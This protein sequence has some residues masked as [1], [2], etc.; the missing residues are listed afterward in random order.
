MGPISSVPIWTFHPPDDEWDGQAISDADEFGNGTITD[1]Y[2]F[3]QWAYDDWSTDYCYCY[4]TGVTNLSLIHRI[5][6]S[7]SVT[8]LPNDPDT[9]T[10]PSDIFTLASNTFGAFY[11][12]EPALMV[13]GDGKLQLAYG[14]TTSI[15]TISTNTLYEAELYVD[16]RN[17]PVDAT[18]NLYLYIDGELWIGMLNY[19]WWPNWSSMKVYLSAGPDYDSNGYFADEGERVEV[20]THVQDIIWT[21]EKP[22]TQGHWTMMAP[23]VA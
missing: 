10:Y 14:E 18:A 9:E 7:F 21:M 8:M 3:Y 22:L 1:A 2:D 12:K 6:C 13:R 5:K 20:T 19:S 17:V 11:Y 23:D 4:K 16:A 15:Q